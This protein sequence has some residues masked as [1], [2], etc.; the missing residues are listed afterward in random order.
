M[1]GG[2]HGDGLAAFRPGGGVG[3]GAGGGVA[4]AGGCAGPGVANCCVNRCERGCVS[5]PREDN[6]KECMLS[7]GA[8]ATPLARVEIHQG[9]YTMLYHRWLLAILL[10][11]AQI[12]VFS[13]CHKDSPRP[14]DT[15]SSGTT[16]SS[17]S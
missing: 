4:D 6:R 12:V 15:S 9:D 3:A 1:P 8:Y 5:A 14:I 16:K 10:M 2:G 13:G 11:T 7:R 17:T